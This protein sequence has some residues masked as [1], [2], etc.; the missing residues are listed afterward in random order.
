M[1]HTLYDVESSGRPLCTH[2]DDTKK[3]V[4]SSSLRPLC[5]SFIVFAHFK[6]R[7]PRAQGGARARDGARGG[8]PAT[9]LLQKWRAARRGGPQAAAGAGPPELAAGLKAG[10]PAPENGPN[11]ATAAR[12]G[13]PSGAIVRSFRVYMSMENVHSPPGGQQALDRLREGAD[14]V[15]IYAC[16]GRPAG[17]LLAGGIGCSVAT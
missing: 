15:R 11:T 10:Q 16:S 12:A 17:Q 9:C 4:E 1:T 6:G 3:T 14:T 7:A 5:P 13:A 8:L 2:K